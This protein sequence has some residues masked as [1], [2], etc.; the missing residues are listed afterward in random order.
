MEPTGDAYLTGITNSSNFPVVGP[1]QATFAG[2]QDAFVTKLSLSTQE[3]CVLDALAEAG[4]SP[5]ALPQS[6]IDTLEDACDAGEDTTID[7]D[8]FFNGNVTMPPPR[9]L[10]VGTNADVNGN[11][12]GSG[13][14]PVILGAGASVNG[15]VIGVSPLIIGGP[16]VQINGSFK[17]NVG[18]LIILEGASVTIGGDGN[19][20]NLE[21]RK[22]GQ[23]TF[24]SNLEN[25]HQSVT[26]LQNSNAFALS[27]QGNLT[28]D[29]GISI[30]QHP[31]AVTVVGGTRNCAGLQ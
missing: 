25:L 3:K 9:I 1:L 13:G 14:I 17:D 19:F 6:V 29:A 23:A 16:G 12:E 28:C 30:T 21:V 7:A 5:S 15:N 18:D 26:M 22:N 24:N 31:S 8:E 4:V 20:N 27:V 2:V 10:V 11:L